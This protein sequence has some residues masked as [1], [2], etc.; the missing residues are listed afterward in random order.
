LTALFLCALFTDLWGLVLGVILII[1]TMVTRVGIVDF[2]A[3]PRKAVYFRN[4]VDF[5]SRMLHFQKTFREK[6]K[7]G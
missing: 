5:P 1:F 7:E 3:E 2:I 6:K 4:T